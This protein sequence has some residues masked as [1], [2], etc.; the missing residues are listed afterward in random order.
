MNSKVE[1]FY[2]DARPWHRE[3]N[4]LRKLVL[5]SELKETFKWNNPCYTYNQANVLIISCFKDRCALSFFKGVLIEDTYKA[6]QAPGA[7]SQSVRLLNFKSVEEILKKKNL[8]KEYIDQ[9]IAIESSGRKIN[10]KKTSEFDIPKE[11]QQKF[12]EDESL[13]KAF[14]SLTPGR[15][16]GYLLFFSG[17]K[18]AATRLSRIEKYIPRILSGKGIN[19]CTCGL[20]NRLPSCDGSHKQLSNR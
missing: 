13:S 6:L 11:L 15:Q 5:N 18:Q 7:N 14:H 4:A 1:A 3:L 20:S 16:R 10:F 9:A 19:D 2:K 8:I 17:A 12:S